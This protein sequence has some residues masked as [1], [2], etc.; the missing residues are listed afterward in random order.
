M[1]KGFTFLLKKTGEWSDNLFRPLPAQIGIIHSYKTRDIAIERNWELIKS[2]NEIKILDFKGDSFVNRSGDGETRFERL[3]N[4][5]DKHSFK[6]LLLNPSSS[7]YIRKRIDCL[8]EQNDRS[9][10]DHKEDIKGIIET[11]RWEKRENPSHEIA[12]RL[13]SE[14]LKWSLVLLDHHVLVCFYPDKKQHQAPCFLLKGD[15]LLGTALSRHFDD[16]WDHKSK[17]ALV[18]YNQFCIIVL[19]GGSFMGKSIVARHL[20]EKYDFS[21]VLCT[22]MIRNQFL[23]ETGDSVL[24]STSTPKMKEADLEKLQEK[25]SEIVLKAVGIYQ[26]RGEKIIIEGMHFTTECL[27]TLSSYDN[28][29]VLGLDNALALNTRLSLKRSTTR[30]NCKTEYP[31]PEMQRMAAIHA[32]LIQAVATKGT[33]I[34]FNDIEEAKRKCE[35]KVEQFFSKINGK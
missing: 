2:S 12:C 3:L 32:K 27:D 4:D 15:S 23:C 30:P 35:E 8:G 5:H 29:L 21:G 6:F 18:S 19:V 16:L 34:Q 14:E 9:V 11:I 13:F 10:E 24:F 20:A 33:V 1:N 25:V 7:T 17:D 28:C 22:D 31:Q 26:G